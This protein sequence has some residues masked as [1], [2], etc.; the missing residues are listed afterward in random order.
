VNS[1]T[2]A[3]GGLYAAC[4]SFYTR[5]REATH[6]AGDEAAG[7]QQQHQQQQMNDMSAI[8]Q[9]AAGSSIQRITDCW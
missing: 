7:D 9:Q 3:G 4:G 6:R 5:V 2:L 8:E 1:F